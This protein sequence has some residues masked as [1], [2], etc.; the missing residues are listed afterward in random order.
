MSNLSGDLRLTTFTK[1]YNFYKNDF[2]TIPFDLYFSLVPN[3]K[4]TINLYITLTSL[5]VVTGLIFPT[6]KEHVYISSI[7]SKT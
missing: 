5:T 7:D 6:Y 3:Q 1:E 2:E 4:S